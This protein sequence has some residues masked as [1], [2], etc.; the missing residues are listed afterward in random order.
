MRRV[1]RGLLVWVSSG[2][3]YG[4]NAPFLAPYFA[5]KAAMDSLAQ[6]YQ[7]EISP[8]GIETSIILPGIFTQGTNHFATAMQP[9]YAELARELLSPPSPLAGWDKVSEEG[10]AKATTPDAD[11]QAV[12]DAIVRVVGSEH[13]SRPFRTYVEFDRGRTNI[14]AGAHD[15]V[16]ELYLARFGTGDLL[17]VR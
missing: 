15:L 8:F 7:L 17:K 3:V 5:A 14:S 12:A 13:G 10:S 9:E 16:R 1:G 4:A 11:P 6:T 2:S